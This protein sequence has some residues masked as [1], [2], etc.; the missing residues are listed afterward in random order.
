[1][2]IYKKVKPGVWKHIKKPIVIK[3]WLAG[4]VNSGGYDVFVKGKKVN[5]NY[6]SSYPKAKR[7]ADKYR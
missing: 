5:K 1:M 4:S 6:I 3:L 2:V 7:L